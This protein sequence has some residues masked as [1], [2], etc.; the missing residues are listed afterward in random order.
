MLRK[1]FQG[2]WNDWFTWYTHTCYNQWTSTLQKAS[3]SNTNLTSSLRILF[4]SIISLNSALS[5]LS[6]SEMILSVLFASALTVCKKHCPCREQAKYKNYLLET[7]LWGRIVGSNI[8]SE[9]TLAGILLEVERQTSSEL[10]GL[11]KKR[12]HSRVR[13]VYWCTRE[14]RRAAPEL[15]NKLSVQHGGALV[16]VNIAFS[17]NKYLTTVGTRAFSASLSPLTKNV[18]NL[19]SL[20]FSGTCSVTHAIHILYFIRLLSFKLKKHIFPG[21]SLSRMKLIA[22]NWWGWRGRWWR[23][24]RLNN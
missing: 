18:E 1:G 9:T 19:R 6:A 15:S 11:Q 3:V 4:E 21:D 23:K 24:N 2:S 7:S 13:H 16:A 20:F 5:F 10:L 22:A 17:Q 14:L 8:N 12:V